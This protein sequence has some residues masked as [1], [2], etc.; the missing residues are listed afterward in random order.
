M[1]DERWE[2]YGAATGIFFVILGVIAYVIAGP[3]PIPDAV[4]TDVVA[5]YVDNSDSLVLSSYLWGV[6]GL[7]YFW[8]LGSLRSYLRRAEGETE[9]LS[10]VAF[11]AGIAG[12]AVFTVGTLVSVALASDIAGAASEDVTLAL[13]EV[14]THAYIYAT[15]A[16]VALAAA[17]SVVSGR[18]RAFPGWLG[19]LGWLVALLTLLGSAAVFAETGPLAIGGALS[20]GGFAVFFLWFLALSVTVTQRAG[21]PPA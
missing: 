21:R 20:V 5:H 9:R 17:T 1:A 3:P 19:W 7:F 2:R 10:A 4:G 6:A 15:F 13:H 18:Y 16:F 12:G 8:F 11:G 14:A